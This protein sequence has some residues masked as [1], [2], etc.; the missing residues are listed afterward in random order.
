MSNRNRALRPSSQEEEDGLKR[1]PIVLVGFMATG[2]TTVGRLLAE[3][4]G[5]HFV[6]LDRAVEEAAGMKIAELFQTHG[7]AVFRRLETEA[8]G[9][10]L[11]QTGTVIATGGGAACREPNLAMM[12]GR[13]LVV[14][15]SA[16]AEEVLRRA[17]R[18]SGRP[19]L[20]G[21]ADPFAR[22]EELLA[23]REPYYARAHV[24]VDTMGKAAEQVAEE[25]LSSLGKQGSG[26]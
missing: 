25:V 22:V 20:D 11:D 21:V 3:R 14:A 12:L 4:L 10:V 8:L 13:A 16:T 18:G 7:E 19:L 17:G 26:T 15:L 2:K 9:R 6:D 23:E 1:R 24:L 5:R